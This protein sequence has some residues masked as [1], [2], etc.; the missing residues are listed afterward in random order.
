MKYI[1]IGAFLSLLCV[2][3]CVNAGIWSN[4]TDYLLL[5]PHRSLTREERSAHVTSEV[6]IPTI[7]YG[8]SFIARET[9]IEKP[10]CYAFW[11]H[12]LCY[13][14][15]HQSDIYHNRTPKPVKNLLKATTCTALIGLI[16]FAAQNIS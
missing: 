3:S 8:A 15:F 12:S 9:K 14:I 4:I 16:T 5:R 1:K 11:T 2:Q 13:Q 10:L 7:L 6:V